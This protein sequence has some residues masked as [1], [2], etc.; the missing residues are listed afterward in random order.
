[1]FAMLFFRNFC[2]QSRDVPSHTRNLI[3]KAHHTV[4]R[5]GLS[6]PFLLMILPFLLMIPARFL[7]QLAFLE[8]NL[9]CG[10]LMPRH[11]SFGFI[12][13]LLKAHAKTC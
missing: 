1:M 4:I 2:S 8:L 13:R 7:S 6:L 12:P 10:Y 11:V 5:S 3:Q 9:G